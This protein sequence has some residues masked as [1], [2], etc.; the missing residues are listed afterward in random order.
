MLIARSETTCKCLPTPYRLFKRLVLLLT[1][2]LHRLWGYNYEDMSID[3][4]VNTFAQNA[5]AAFA[6]TSGF[7]DLEL[8]V[9]Y[10]HGDEGPE[11]WYREQLPGLTALK[12]EWDPQVL[13]RYMNPVVV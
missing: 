13:F 3:D 12:E 5:R 7:G 9:T 6:S 10:S 2:G 1:R 4:Q 8:Y 11:V